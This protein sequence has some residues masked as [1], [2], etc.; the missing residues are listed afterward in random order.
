MHTEPDM[1]VHANNPSYSGGRNW[2]D[3][4]L[5]STQEKKVSETPSQPTSQTKA[6]VGR[7]QLEA[8]SGQKA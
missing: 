7:L 5:R 1:L 8:S 6:K 4:S 3:C 2:E